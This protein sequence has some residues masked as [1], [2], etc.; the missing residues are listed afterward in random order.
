M[1][2]SCFFEV[3]DSN[4]PS[5]TAMLFYTAVVQMA[6]SIITYSAAVSS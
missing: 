5:G 1:L 6:F 2:F 4:C 3:R